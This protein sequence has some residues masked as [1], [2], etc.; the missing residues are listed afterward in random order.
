MPSLHFTYALYKEHETT[1]VNGYKQI[2]AKNG[3]YIIN[4]GL[5]LQKMEL[6][7]SKFFEFWLPDW[8]GLVGKTPTSDQFS[9]HLNGGDIFM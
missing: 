6:R 5:D 1:I 8:K 7:L 2:T 9:E 3:K 4:P